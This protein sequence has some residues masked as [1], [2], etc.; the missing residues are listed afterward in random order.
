VAA[1]VA[2]TWHYVSNKILNL[3]AKRIEPRAL[4]VF[5]TLCTIDV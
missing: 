3:K 2:V 5:V 1:A 4:K